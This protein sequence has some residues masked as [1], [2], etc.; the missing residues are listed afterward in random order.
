MVECLKS[1][2]SK[3]E[4]Y[5]KTGIKATRKERGFLP[6]AKAK[7]FHLVK[8][9]KK[10][11]FILIEVIIAI[12]L[13]TIA[14]IPLIKVPYNM[15]NSQIT[16]CEKA[17]LERIAELGFYEISKQIFNEKPAFF[18]L[19]G[20]KQAQAEE[21]TLVFSEENNHLTLD[22]FASRPLRATYKIWT[23]RPKSPN[24][25]LTHYLLKIELNLTHSK[26]KKSAKFQRSF[27][28]SVEKPLSINE[29][30]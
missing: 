13:L 15:L 9:M 8:S 27:I 14:A 4:V 25:Q 28:Y 1:C 29:N 2:Y 24:D 10:R 6:T 16:L 21:R 3:G 5:V 22:G 7:G 12:S 23:L 18:K 26:S 17:E 19:L 30:F 11:S 20:T